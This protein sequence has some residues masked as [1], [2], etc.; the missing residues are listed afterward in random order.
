MIVPKI[1]AVVKKKHAG[2]VAISMNGKV[3]AVGKNSVE[4]LKKAKQV[5]PNI[6]DKEFLISRILSKYIAV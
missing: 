1:S 3:V 5:D 6:E 2:E 4:A